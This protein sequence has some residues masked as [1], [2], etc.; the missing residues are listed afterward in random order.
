MVIHYFTYGHI[1]LHFQLQSHHLADDDSLFIK[2]VSLQMWPADQVIN[3]TTYI[4]SLQG[5]RAT[6][7]PASKQPKKK[8]KKTRPSTGRKVNAKPV[9]PTEFIVLGL[10]SKEEAAPS[11]TTTGETVEIQTTT[12]ETGTPSESVTTTETTL[13]IEES[14]SV[15]ET[16]AGNSSDSLLSSLEQLREEHPQL[17]SSLRLTLLPIAMVGALFLF[18]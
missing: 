2:C 15:R 13:M 1:G 7:R 17:I 6:P 18:V 16:T 11:T 3:Q 5:E 10:N 12:V 9:V 4:E 14:T 8:K